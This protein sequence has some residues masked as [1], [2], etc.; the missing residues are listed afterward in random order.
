MG[1]GSRSLSIPG[2][3]RCGTLSY[4]PINEDANKSRLSQ[5]I[6]LPSETTLKRKCGTVILICVP[7]PM[8]VV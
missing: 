8:I 2:M 4:K 5:N 3:L 7:L 1:M 6:H